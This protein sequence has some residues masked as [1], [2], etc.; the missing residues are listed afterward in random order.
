MLQ[1]RN[2]KRPAQAA[3]RFAVDAV[4]EGLLDRE[5]ALATIDAGLAR[6]AAA[7]DLRPD[8]DYEVL[9]RGVAAS[10]GAAKGAIV[11]T[12]ADAVAAAADGRDVILVRPFT[13]ADDVAGFHAAQGHP[14][15]RG[16]QGQPRRARGP[17]HGPP[18]CVGGLAAWRSTS[19][20][21]RCGWA[22][23]LQEGD[24]IAIDGTSGSRDHR[25]RAPGGSGGRPQLRDRARV[26]RRA[27]PPGRARQRRHARRT[28]ARPARSAP[29]ASGCAAPSTCSW[30]R[31][32]SPRCGR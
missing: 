5:Q 21:A 14:H 15:L 20:R 3:V 28:R 13:E 2:A 19:R 26:G 4:E 6:R 7:P 17:R 31:T 1:T 18:V 25:R 24:L 11:F 9:A 22:T 16:R 32:A 23:E 8:A 27:A 10:P 12:A 29:R 30:R